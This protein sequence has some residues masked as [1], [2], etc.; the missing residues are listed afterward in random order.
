MFAHPITASVASP[1]IFPTTGITVDTA[2]FVVF[3]VTPSTVS[4]KPPSKVN[5]VTNNVIIIPNTH[6]VDEFKN[7]DIFDILISSDIPEIILKLVDINI[8]G[9]IKF[10]IVF[11]I[12]FVNNSSNGCKTP[13]EVI[14]PVV[15]INVNNIGSKEFINPTRF[16]TVSFTKDIQSEKL[17]S[18]IVAT[19]I[20]CTKYVICD[21]L[22]LFSKDSFI[23]V[24]RL[25]I[26]IIIN[27][28]PK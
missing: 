21:T 17:V 18:K 3:A 12:M 24:N 7:F 19:N 20:N 5:T 4:V 10:D 9:K 14:D 6:T 15:S 16:C 13:A 23:A 1:N 8:I 27:I 11:P 2:A 26:T 22:F 28:I 25:C